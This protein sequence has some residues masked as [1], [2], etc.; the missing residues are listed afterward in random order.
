MKP[1]LKVLK[2]EDAPKPPQDQKQSPAQAE[3]PFAV[4]A[5]EPPQ[6]L[7][8]IFA[9]LGGTRREQRSAAAHPDEQPF[10]ERKQPR[11]AECVVVGTSRSDFT[12][13]SR[14]S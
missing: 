4:V 5:G 12:P 10:P 8:E 14:K 11:R 13:V 1:D 2:R 3:M 7:A 9:V 6:L